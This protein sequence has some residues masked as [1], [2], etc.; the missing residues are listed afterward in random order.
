MGSGR[1]R[2]FARVGRIDT[3]ISCH[4]RLRLRSFH[5]TGCPRGVHRFVPV[6]P[7]PL[8]QASLCLGAPAAGATRGGARRTPSCRCTVRISGGF[9]RSTSI[10]CLRASDAMGILGV[11]LGLALLVWLAF[12]GGELR[13]RAGQVGDVMYDIVF[14]APLPTRQFCEQWCAEEDNKAFRISWH[15]KLASSC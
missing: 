5:H 8:S 3:S 1:V 13:R 6:S 9:P 4:R 14:E 11:L 10:A 12:R 15:T 2:Y 7:T